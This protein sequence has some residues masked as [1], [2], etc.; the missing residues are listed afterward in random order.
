MNFALI[1]PPTSLFDTQLCL[2]LHFVIYIIFYDDQKLA[3]VIVV[4][5]PIG[6]PI[7]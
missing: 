2:E 5:V 1:F 4:T 6:C 7:E 3:I